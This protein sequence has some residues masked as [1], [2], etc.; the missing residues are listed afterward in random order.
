VKYRPCRL[1]RGS[2][3]LG[4]GHPMLVGMA[5]APVISGQPPCE[6]HPMMMQLNPPIP[7]DTPK[8]PA[9]A[10]M[11]IDYSQEHYVLFVCFLIESGECW[12]FPN[13]DVRLQKNLTMGIRPGPACACHADSHRRED[14]TAARPG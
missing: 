7:L 2:R 12:V 1:K 10:H 8:G 14:R 5:H 3:R 13:K 11:T 9:F 4:P 6:I